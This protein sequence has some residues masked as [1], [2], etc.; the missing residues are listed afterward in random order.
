MLRQE[1]LGDLA[2]VQKMPEIRRVRV[3][4]LLDE[5]TEHRQV[6][7]RDHHRY[8]HGEV[9]VGR[10]H[11]L[12]VRERIRSWRARNLRRGGGSLR[13]RG[14]AIALAKDEERWEEQEQR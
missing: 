13:G 11:C 1:Q 4:E 7:Q 12:V 9:W 14:C 10:P 2:V 5:R 3:R 8:Q 6:P